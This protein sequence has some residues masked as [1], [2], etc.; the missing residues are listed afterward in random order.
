MSIIN[1]IRLLSK[2]LAAKIAAGE[3]V[4]RPL[5]IVKELVE[6]SVDA[7]ATQITVEIEKGG[8]DYI[9][10]TDNGCGIAR[11]QVEMAFKRHATSKIRTDEDL[12]AIRTLGFRG[13]ALASIAAVSHTELITKTAGNKTGTL[14]RVSA[15][16]TESISDAACDEG[17]TIVVRDLF[18]NVPAR[19]KFLRSDGAESSLIIDYM[20]KMAIAF[21][22]VRVRLISNRS[23]L[24]STLG[25]GDLLKAIQ[26][27]YGPDAGTKLLPVSCRNESY[28]LQGYISAPSE[29]LRH[30][31]YQVFFI[32]SR[33]VKS[34]VMEKALDEAYKDKL[35]EGRYPAAF[36][37]LSMDPSAVDV[38]IHPH[39]TEV[40]FY[41]E[42]EVSAYV[43]RAL[44]SALL[45]PD[46][47][48]Y[49]HDEVKAER[50]DEIEANGAE[51][52]ENAES[53]SLSSDPLVPVD[54]PFINQINLS[55]TKRKEDDFFYKLRSDK[56]KE[57]SPT[58][59]QEM[60]PDSG[61]DV[62]TRRLIFSSLTPVGQVFAT[63]ILAKDEHYL[64]LLD[65]HAAHERVLYEQ[66]LA[67]FNEEAPDTQTLIMPYLLQISASRKAKALE[68]LDLL[69][70]IG[71]DIEDFGPAELVVKGIPSCMSL[72]EAED[73]LQ[74]AV[75]CEGGD[76]QA[77]RDRI[78]TASCKAA[79]KANRDLKM[80]EIRALFESLDKCE[81]PYSCPHGRPTYIRLSEY[82]LEKLFKRK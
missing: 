82:E 74:E 6:N 9:R 58:E 48:A 2:D 68:R 8:K 57:D 26:T 46:A 33:L 69:R 1:E 45:D 5:S 14:I 79:I 78:I 19:R 24:F 12:G 71:Y 31:R 67:R 76:L 16:E 70:G 38:N 32:N 11:D 30:R 55:S 56:E 23:I 7:G 37:F 41:D 60:L 4:E 34:R 75:N 29:S 3:V 61:Y 20:S 59:V 51:G 25:G 28:S 52:S 54:R 39:K 35:F 22:S 13:E 62:G 53:S 77:N 63:Y 15:S 72:E 73:F 80:E 81:N 40:R 27:V 21:P 18:Y 43:V 47:S 36:L 10:V 66:L 49:R 65:Q 17:T 42:G 50:S 64:Y 44:R